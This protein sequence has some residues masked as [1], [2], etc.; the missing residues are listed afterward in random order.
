VDIARFF[1]ILKKSIKRLRV[2]KFRPSATNETAPGSGAKRRERAPRKN[3]LFKTD[4]T[5]EAISK[6]AP[7]S[8]C[9]FCPC[10]NG[11]NALVA[12]AT[13]GSGE[14]S[15]QGWI[16]L[17]RSLLDHPRYSDEKWFRVFVHLLLLATHRARRDTFKGKVITLR[18]GQLITS[19]PEIEATLGIH[20]S[21]VRRI[22]ETL[23]IDRQIFWESGNKN[24][25]ITIVNWE[26]FQETQPQESAKPTDNRQT[27]DRQPTDH[28]V[29]IKNG[30]NEKNE[31]NGGKGDG[32][33]C[34]RSLA[35]TADGSAPSSSPDFVSSSSSPS[36]APSA[37]RRHGKEEPWLFAFRSDPEFAGVD[38]TKESD[39]IR[40]HARKTGKKFDSDY[41]RN[42]LRKHP[43]KEK[44][45]GEEGYLLDG[46]F[47]TRKEAN[48]LAASSPSVLEVLSRKGKTAIRYPNGKIVEKSGL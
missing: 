5:T 19:L 33:T 41:F 25:L 31:K 15:R 43:P 14:M 22:L 3:A 13:K 10:R 2:S 35:G 12:P 36:P 28:P 1:S 6:R 24:R 11:P 23:K 29:V 37:Q 27:T 7:E 46:R 8:T 30:E 44:K 48:I 21:S 32:K 40:R 9:N 17:H 26:K 39:N 18:P 34:G 45:T 4:S 16:K 47:L 20:Q 38:I 42:C